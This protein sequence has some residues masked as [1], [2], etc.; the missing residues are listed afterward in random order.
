MGSMGKT[1]SPVFGVPLAP[2]LPLESHKMIPRT[3]QRPLAG[4]FLR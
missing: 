3:S 2:S 4:T 1:R